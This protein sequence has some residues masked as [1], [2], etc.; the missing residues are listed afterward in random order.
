MNYWIRL[1]YDVK[2]IIQPHSVIINYIQNPKETVYSKLHYLFQQVC[3]KESENWS[4]FY[5][6][7][8]DKVEC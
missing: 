8:K 4:V 2:N 7:F 5:T 6:L 1:S 3:N